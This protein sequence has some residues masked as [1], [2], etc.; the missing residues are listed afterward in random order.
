MSGTVRRKEK[1]HEKER[2]VWS[3]IPGCNAKQ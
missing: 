3:G 2:G 1:G